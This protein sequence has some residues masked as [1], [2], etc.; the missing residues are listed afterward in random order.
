MQGSSSVSSSFLISCTIH[1]HAILDD[2][3]KDEDEESGRKFKFDPTSF[4]TYHEEFEWPLI[5]KRP[6]NMI[7]ESLKS[8]IRA[9]GT[10]VYHKQPHSIP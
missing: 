3:T 8:I 9:Y 2:N 5:S 7:L 1:S 4:I 10:A 6:F